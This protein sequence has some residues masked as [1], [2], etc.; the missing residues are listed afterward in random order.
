MSVQNEFHSKY[1]PRTYKQVVGQDQAVQVLS[2]MK[3]RIPHALCFHGPSGTGKTTLARIVG[4]ELGCKGSDYREINAASSRG[5]DTVRE[6]ESKMNLAP[7]HGSCRVY[8]LDEA[9][10]L[11]GDAQSALLK[12]LED[13]PWATYFILATT[14]PEK[15]LPTIRT[16]C[17]EI[18]MKTV[19]DD[20]IMLLLKR[21]VKKE[22]LKITDAVLEQLAEA[23]DGSPRRAVIGLQRIVDLKT[24]E[25]QLDA[26]VST[27]EKRQSM[28]LCR[29]LMG[30]RSSIRNWADV[31]ETIAAIPDSEL[32]TFRRQILGWATSAMIG[33][34]DGKGG[35]KKPP[36][37]PNE[38][39]YRVI[40]AFS[41]HWFDSG[42]AGLIASCC[43]VLFAE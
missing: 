35:R 22:K 17:T 40:E 41:N 2:S 24:E 26:I 34:K 32:E 30:Y 9:H 42:R 3:G 13:A 38:H 20:D 37:K 16:R 4:S 10:R 36:S 1:R 43:E 21:I 5:V 6:I 19:G 11:T 33:A 23:A 31:A 7:M 15:L 12:M 8:C 27:D 18:A 14:H 25:E 39:A 29:F 28:E